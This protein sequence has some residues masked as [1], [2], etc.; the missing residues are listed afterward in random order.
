M[1]KSDTNAACLAPD[2]DSA[3]DPA[4]FRMDLVDP[5]IDAIPAKKLGLGI[6][7]RVSSL[8]GA[9]PLGAARFYP[10]R[11]RLLILLAALYKLHTPDLEAAGTRSRLPVTAPP[12]CA[13][14]TYVLAP[15][16]PVRR[17]A[18]SKY[19]AP[20]ARRFTSASPR[21]RVSLMRFR[22]EE[23]QMWEHFSV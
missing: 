2:N 22:R 10:P 13:I 18:L 23:G 19:C 6:N 15:L 11:A 17:S 3:F 7:N 1:K 16:R 9:I 21:R 4:R 12:G 20:V 5:A 8:F 14:R